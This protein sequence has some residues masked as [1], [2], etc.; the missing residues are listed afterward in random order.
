MQKFLLIVSIIVVI[1]VTG[2]FCV[3][4]ATAIIAGTKHWFTRK[5]DCAE[6]QDPADR[7]I[8]NE[9]GCTDCDIKDEAFFYIFR[10]YSM[11]F[12]VMAAVAEF[13]RFKFFQESFKIFR[14]FWGRGFLH[15]FLGFLTISGASQNNHANE[16]DTQL[17]AQIFGYIMMGLGVMHM[18]FSCLCFK[19]YGRDAEKESS[20]AAYQAV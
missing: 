9:N 4:L 15:I 6:I 7:A 20:E 17:V 12:C 18:V 13:P 16:K 2:V 3:N 1:V 11:F 14:Y 5:D 10:I 8:C 19:V